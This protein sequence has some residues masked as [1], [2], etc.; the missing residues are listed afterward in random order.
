MSTS[1]KTITHEN[2]TLQQNEKV[3]RKHIHKEQTLRYVDMVIQ[4]VAVQT[5]YASEGFTGK[6]LAAIY[7]LRIDECEQRAALYRKHLTDLRLVELKTVYWPLQQY[8]A[9]VI[10]ERTEGRFTALYQKSMQQIK[11]HY[12]TLNRRRNKE[13]KEVKEIAERDQN[14]AQHKD[15]FIS[16]PVFLDDAAPL[17]ETSPSKK[18]RQGSG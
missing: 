10:R 15:A 14:S 2:W 3:K 5:Y 1:S 16:Q 6:A 18:P 4:L 8:D 17:T 11:N 7:G 12:T 9:Q 13:A